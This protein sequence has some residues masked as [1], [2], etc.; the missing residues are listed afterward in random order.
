MLV[1]CC[2]TT[3]ARC[4]GIREAKQ[5]DEYAGRGLP[6]VP[7]PKECDRAAFERALKAV[8]AIAEYMAV[9]RAFL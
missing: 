1:G 9:L 5:K 6:N 2:G 3:R 4:C 8:F 7:N